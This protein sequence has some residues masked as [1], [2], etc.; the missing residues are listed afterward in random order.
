MI[1]ARGLSPR[2]SFERTVLSDGRHRVGTYKLR[3]FRLRARCAAANTLVPFA[4]FE[5]AREVSNP[6]RAV[7]SRVFCRLN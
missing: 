6:H 3:R 2:E 1:P 4:F 7:I 5:S